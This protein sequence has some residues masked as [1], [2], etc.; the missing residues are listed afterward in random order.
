MRTSRLFMM[1]L[2]PGLF[3]EAILEAGRFGGND[4]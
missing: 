2:S 1:A 3:G 4:N